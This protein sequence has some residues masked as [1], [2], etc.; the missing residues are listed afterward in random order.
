MPTIGTATIAI[1]VEPADRPARV[2]RP[3]AAQR[4]PYRHV[5]LFRE[6]AYPDGQ[7]YADDDEDVDGE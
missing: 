3:A 1:R 4:L 7:P 5:D 2:A 6:P